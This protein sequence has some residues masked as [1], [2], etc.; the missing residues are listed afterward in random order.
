MRRIG[1]QVEQLAQQLGPGDAVDAG[2]VDDGDAGGAAAR[3]ALDVVEG[4]QRPLARQGGAGQLGHQFGQLGVASGRLE[5]QALHMLVEAEVRILDP[6]RRHQVE[7]HVDQA[8]AEAGQQ[9]QALGDALA[10]R[11]EAEAG[12]RTGQVEQRQA[13]EVHRCPGGLEVEEH[14]VDAAE[15]LHRIHLRVH[16]FFIVNA[17]G[18]PC[19]HGACGRRPHRN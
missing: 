7:R 3:Q 2:V 11:V 15:L 6:E 19:Q 17:Y 12:G 18:R 8:A 16:A 13:A 10:H 1:L 9:V 5:P 4:P 14:R